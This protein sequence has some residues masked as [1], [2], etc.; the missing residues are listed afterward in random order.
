MCMARV[1]CMIPFLLL[2]SAIF[3]VVLIR[4]GVNG[5]LVLIIGKFFQIFIYFYL[6][7]AAAAPFMQ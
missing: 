3:F 4:L 5:F 7:M 2:L 1:K 6:V